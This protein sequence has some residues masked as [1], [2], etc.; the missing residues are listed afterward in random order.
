MC[1]SRKFYLASLTKYANADVNDGDDDD[2]LEDSYDED[3]AIN[4]GLSKPE[5]KTTVHF[6]ASPESPGIK[7]RARRN[8]SPEKSP[9]VRALKMSDPKNNE[10]RSVDVKVADSKI[11][12]KELPELTAI[13]EILNDMETSQSIH[14][15]SSY[16]SSKSEKSE[17]IDVD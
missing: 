4:Y 12:V 5:R 14:S 17:K 13:A 1:I 16:T 11:P 6:E 9:L 7:T 10:N 15:V 3:V 8:S 2:S